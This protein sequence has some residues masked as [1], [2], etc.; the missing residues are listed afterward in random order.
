[1]EAATVKFNDRHVKVGV[2]ALL[3]CQTSARAEKAEAAWKKVQMI[4]H[5]NN[6]GLPDLPFPA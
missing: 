3:G 4:R 6:H 5:S 1:M 2:I